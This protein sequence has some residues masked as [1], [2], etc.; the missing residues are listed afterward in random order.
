MFRSVVRLRVDN[1]LID[2]VTCFHPILDGA[3]FSSIGRRYHGGNA[4]FYVQGK[5]LIYFSFCSKIPRTELKFQDSDEIY[6]GAEYSIF[7]GTRSGAVVA[8]KNFAGPHAKTVTNMQSYTHCER[9]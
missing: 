3:L 8:V 1:L 6:T 9:S 5:N 7:T 2:I 4:P